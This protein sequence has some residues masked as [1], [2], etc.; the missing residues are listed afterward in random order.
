M[1]HTS[2]RMPC[3][4]G[5]SVQKYKG[6]TAST[7]QDVTEN[8]NTTTLSIVT[9]GFFIG[10]G[11]LLSNIPGV[12]GFG[13]LEQVTAT[14][15]T[16]SHTIYFQN[17]VNSWEAL[18]N[19]SVSGGSYF[20]DGSTLSGIM[21]SDNVLRIENLETSN[22]LVWSNLTELRGNVNNL[23]TSNGLVWSNITE[24]R[25][26]INN[27]ETSNGLVWSNLTELR[28][29]VNNLETSN[30]LVWSNITELRGNIN[31]LETS[32]GLV[33]SNLIELRG[34]VTNLETSNDLVWSNIT[35]LRGNVNNL[36]TSNDLVWSNLIELRGNVTN[37]ETS[38]DLVWSNLTNILGRT[39]LSNSIGITTG[40]TSGDILYASADNQLSKLSIGSTG[41]GNVLTVIG[42]TSIAWQPP[43]GGGGSS[44]GNLQQVTDNG[45]T[46]TA[47]VQLTNTNTSLHAYGNV[48]VEGNVTA[49]TYYGDGTN[50]SGIMLSDNVVRIQNLESNLVANALRITNLESN[51]VANALR[52]T[53]LESNLVAN[54]LRITNLE[55]NLVAN[56]LRI[57]NLE[58]NL[59]ANALRITNLES[60]LVAN[61]LR[62][63]NLET[64]NN[65]L[66]SQTIISNSA[67]I[68]TGFTKG[69]ILYA[70]VDNQLSKLALGTDTHVLTANVT[71]GLPE[72]QAPTGGGSS[73]N[74]ITENAS[75]TGIS[76]TSPQYTLQVG[77]NV[78]IDDIGSDVLWVGGTIYSTK[79][80]E[81]F[82]TIRAEEMHMNKIFI[83]NTTIVAERPARQI[84][85][86]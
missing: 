73:F 30:G 64:S 25:G 57:T 17:T 37:L 20:G 61:A 26:N 11:G 40:F 72:W 1:S 68:T 48:I 39:I 24:L 53:N 65:L 31:N 86:K 10:D 76:N 3:S 82:G 80:V 16:T 83:R 14:G 79:D 42:S 36:E 54:A 55:S 5:R 62:I 74:N 29:N 66:W 50:L 18:G 35:G 67:T 4:V 43:T 49:Q 75:N 38:N 85:L 70:S 51:L 32:N 22:G 28:G 63:T 59:V 7:L 52:I 81:A 41:V 23:E 27:L 15:N 45:E 19:V 13:T 56:A 78:V 21:L 34:N 77:S 33:W 46:T 69:D 2:I 71:S 84:R 58:S 12:S 47:F 44:V 6:T 8:G 60:N 9:D